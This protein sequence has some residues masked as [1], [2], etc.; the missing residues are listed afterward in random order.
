MRT[1]ILIS[2]CL[3]AIA[4]F[5]ATSQTIPSGVKFEPAATA[6]QSV[7]ER[8]RVGYQ[9]VLDVQIFRHPEL[10][11]RLPVSPSG[12]ISL[13]RIDKPI[14][15][16]CKTERELADEIAAAYQE[17]VLRRAEVRVF[18]AEQ[19]S[20]SIGIIGA[21]EKPGNYLLDRRI[22]LLELLA[23]AGGPKKEA[24]TRM[25]VVR[26][27]SSFSCKQGPEPNAND[28]A[29]FG[30][31][32]RDVQEGKVNFWMQPGD[33]VSVLSADIIYVYGNV[34]KQG[35]LSV[36]EPITLTQAIVSSEGLKPATKKDRIRVLRQRPGSSERE[37]LVFNL[38]DID[39]GKVKDPILEPNDIVAVSED[40]TKSILLGLANSIKATV[41][42]VLYR[43]P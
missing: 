19:K 21:I 2:V 38:N 22:H 30:F 39:K 34:N 33:V 26:T 11:Q 24:G 37:E 31:K 42:N 28:A 18:V 23:R 12:T 5:A 27:G 17:K 7:D 25:I 15:A 9:D 3:V 40:K 14:I 4:V 8:Y 32:L 29:D 1:R 10:N 6:G 20:Q 36:Q 35:A 43:V 16:V 13:F 41:P